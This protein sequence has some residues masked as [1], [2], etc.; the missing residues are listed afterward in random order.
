MSVDLDRLQAALLQSGIR[1]KDQPLY[2]VINQL[3]QS[4]KDLRTQINNSISSITNIINNLTFDGPSPVVLFGDSNND[5]FDPIPIPGKDGKDGIQGLRGIPGEDGKDGLDSFIPGP[6][7]RDGFPGLTIPGLDGLPGE[8]GFPGTP[9]PIGPTGAAGSSGADGRPGPPGMD[10]ENY[11]EDNVFPAT[12]PSTSGGST[13]PGGSDTQVQFNDAGSFGGDSG[14]TYNKTTDALALLGLLDLSGAAAGQIKFPATA[15]PSSNVN[16][17]DDYERGSWTPVIGGSGGTSGQ[18]YTTQV[19]RYVKIGR[20]VAASFW[21]T[22][23]NKGT[24]TSNCEIQQLPFTTTNVAG[25]ITAVQLAWASLATA[26][27]TMAAFI[28]PN[29]TI[30]SIGR[31]TAASTGSGSDLTTTDLNNG[32]SIAGSLFYFTDG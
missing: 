7:G 5:P 6:T 23:S 24:I 31:N 14:L 11:Y 10:G 19:G 32:T 1:F 9:G 25:M 12:A 26:I 20:F 4:E 18:T 21:I 13:S 29:A 3:I 30:G 27:V 15:N 2:Q 8:D 17:L 28:Q 22:F 16:T